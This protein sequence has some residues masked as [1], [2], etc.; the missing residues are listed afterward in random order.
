M[1]SRP[2]ALPIN[3]Y[4]DDIDKFNEEETER[5][6]ETQIDKENEEIFSGETDEPIDDL[7]SDSEDIQLPDN[8]T[9]RISH[10][11]PLYIKFNELLEKG[12][13]ERR[14]VAFYINI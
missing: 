11:D 12:V 5:S 8:I 10:A 9:Y 6:T 2:S 3:D 4:E 13:T 1:N 14:E 7:D